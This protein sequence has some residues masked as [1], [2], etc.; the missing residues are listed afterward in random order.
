MN[1]YIDE[2]SKRLDARY[3]RQMRMNRLIQ[4]V[5]MRTGAVL[6]T[7]CS[8]SHFKAGNT[9]DAIVCMFLAIGYGVFSFPKIE[10]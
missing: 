5:I 10:K 6:L 1:D 9:F 2:L 4:Q 8:I 7:M 3:L